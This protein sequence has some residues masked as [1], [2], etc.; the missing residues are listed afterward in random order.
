MQKSKAK[1]EMVN[2]IHVFKEVNDG[3]LYASSFGFK[4]YEIP[5]SALD[6]A[7]VIEKNTPDIISNCLASMEKWIRKTLIG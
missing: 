2:V 5:A 4:V 3:N 1:E 6:H 7:K